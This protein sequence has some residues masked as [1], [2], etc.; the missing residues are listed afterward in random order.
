MVSAGGRFPLA[1][2]RLSKIEFFSDFAKRVY[3]LSK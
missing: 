3:E 2:L 1:F